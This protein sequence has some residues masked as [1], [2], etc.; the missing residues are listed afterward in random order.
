MASQSINATT[1][2]CDH[3]N[4]RRRSNQKTASSKIPCAA[5]FV[6]RSSRF[7]QCFSRAVPCFHLPNAANLFRTLLNVCRTAWRP[8]RT[9]F[10]PFRTSP[11]L[12]MR[13]VRKLKSHAKPQ[14]HKDRKE[15]KTHR[16]LF[17]LFLFAALRLCVNLLTSSEFN[18]HRLQLR[19]RFLPHDSPPIRKKLIVFPSEPRT[20]RRVLMN[21][22][23]W[24]F[25]NA[26]SA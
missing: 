3:E 5:H 1:S 24:I 8:A 10:K 17:F 4:S 19:C 9:A 2:G 15:K 22:D 14:R 6:S 21:S 11:W 18:L 23:A 25:R 26:T 13:G 7:I 12:I 20:I 16:H